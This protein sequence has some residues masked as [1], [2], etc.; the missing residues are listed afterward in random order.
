MWDA[1]IQGISRQKPDDSLTIQ[2]HM[3]LFPLQI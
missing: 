1:I 3:N 2:M